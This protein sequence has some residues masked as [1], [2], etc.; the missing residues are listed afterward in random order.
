[1]FNGQIALFVYFG[2]NTRM[3]RGRGKLPVTID[4]FRSAVAQ[5]RKTADDLD[6]FIGDMSACGV[7]T[8]LC[9]S[10]A[11]FDFTRKAPL[12][13]SALRTDLERQRQGLRKPRSMASSRVKKRRRKKPQ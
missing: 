11:I 13:L 4:E 1:M 6:A 9:E 2:L 5:L 10:K 3:A 7:S 12:T 8:L